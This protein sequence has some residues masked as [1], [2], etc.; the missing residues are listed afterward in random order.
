MKKY[1][2]F[3]K[4]LEDNFFYYDNTEN[5]NIYKKYFREKSY[6]ETEIFEEFLNQNKL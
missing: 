3:A 5:G 4:F 2:E 6:T 1:F